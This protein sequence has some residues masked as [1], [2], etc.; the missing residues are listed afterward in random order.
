MVTTAMD[1]A[2]KSLGMD[3]GGE[4]DDAKTMVRAYL[5]EPYYKGLIN[6]FTGVNVASRIG[7]SELIY[8]ESVMDRDYPLPFQ[9]RAYHEHL[10]L[11]LQLQIYPLTVP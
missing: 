3:P 2:M 6:Y 5:G 11:D 9:I 10:P 1:V 8:R 4:D 7:L